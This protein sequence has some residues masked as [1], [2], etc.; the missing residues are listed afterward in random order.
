GAVRF[1]EEQ[2][3]D[4]AVN[5]RVVAALIEGADTAR[6][7]LVQSGTLT[8]EVAPAYLDAPRLFAEHSKALPRAADLKQLRSDFG[9]LFRDVIVM[10]KEATPEAGSDKWGLSHAELTE[11]ATA[12][13]ARLVEYKL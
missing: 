3:I 10:A 8:R 11:W 12:M 13:E 7:G 9:S 6:M 5:L 1:R 4:T 2:S